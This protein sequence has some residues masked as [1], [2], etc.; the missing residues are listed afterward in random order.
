M[1]GGAVG[2]AR[3]AARLRPVGTAEGALIIG[4]MNTSAPT[5]RVDTVSAANPAKPIDTPGPIDVVL[6]V[7]SGSIRLIATDRVDTFVEVVPTDATDNG[8]AK[9][10]QR[11][12]VGYR[13]GV[14]RIESE[15][16]KHRLLGNAGS[17]AVT[18]QLPAGSQVQ[19]KAAVADF[20]GVGRLG[21]V[22][23]EGATGSVNLEQVASANLTLQD[24]AIAIGRLG[25]TAEI[26]TQRGDITIA[27]AVQG[28]VVLRTQSGSLSICAARGVSAALDAG[29][30]HGRVHNSLLNADGAPVLNI[31]AT[32]AEGDI[33]ARSL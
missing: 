31:H 13:D 6:D 28:T 29:T 7:P 22:T 17:V 12:H 24:G 21:D 4:V 5:P 10:A 18:V 20:H 23:Y 8:D 30:G 16:A 32:T 33:T 3:P 2:P 27:E 11:V 26:S 15:V 9:A 14:L 1:A 25:G 19:A